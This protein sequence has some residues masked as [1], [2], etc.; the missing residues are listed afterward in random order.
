MNKVVDFGFVDWVDLHFVLW[1]LKTAKNG[2]AESKKR[3]NFH[4]SGEC[5]LWILSRCSG[6]V[7]RQ[8]CRVNRAH[9]FHA[10]KPERFTP[11]ST[12][13][14]QVMYGKDF[15]LSG[16][17]RAQNTI[18]ALPAY[19][20]CVKSINVIKQQSGK[21]TFLL[22]KLTT[23]VHLDSRFLIN[24]KLNYSVFIRVEQ[25]EWIQ[26]VSSPLSAARS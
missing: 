21:M 18:I 26:N 25:S 22:S 23:L 4:L 2:D 9:P 11:C 14:P 17:S 8:A 15:K 5:K 10:L 16:G 20:T 1:I 13:S 12:T 19:S 24:F 3:H 7:S 6:F